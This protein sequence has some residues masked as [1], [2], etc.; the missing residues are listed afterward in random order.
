MNL[1]I[2]GI[3]GAAILCMV[4]SAAPALGQGTG[5]VLLR[6]QLLDGD[7]KAPVSGAFI[8]LDAE[9]WGVLTDS[10]GAFTLPVGT[11]EAYQIKVRQLGYR[12][13]VVTVTAESARR[14]FFLQ[15]D[16]DPVEIEGLRVLVQRFEDR[17]RG[18]FGAVDVLDQKAL[19]EAPGGTGVDFVKRVVPFARPCDSETEALCLNQMGRIEPLT[20][21]VDG[22]R[23]SE[24]MAE[25]EH[26]DPRSLYMVEVFRRTGQVHMYS[27]G[28]V[29]RLLEAGSELPPLSFGCGQV[30]LPGTVIG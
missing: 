10:I 23:V 16:P 25:L 7:T 13:L 21:C 9:S 8:A 3:A 28:Y 22:H 29:E 19:S 24:M 12:D 6:G 26:V 15:L 11:A 1:R 2:F 18:P 4:A 14:P 5:A 30:G 20:V 27:R 17:R